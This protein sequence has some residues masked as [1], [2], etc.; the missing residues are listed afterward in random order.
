LSGGAGLWVKLATSVGGRRAGPHLLDK[1]TTGLQFA[2]IEKLL[3][4]LRRLVEQRNTVRVIEHNLAVIETAD[5]ILDLGR[6]AASG[7]LPPTVP[8][9]Q[10]VRRSRGDRGI[11]G[12]STA[13][14][15]APTARTTAKPTKNAMVSATLAAGTL[16]E[17]MRSAAMTIAEP[18]TVSPSVDHLMTD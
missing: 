9:P 18:S 10:R 16:A 17:C 7:T 11:Y 2:D 12:F 6:R 15:R 14:T 3:Q 8:R 5:W 13:T 1:P 4:I